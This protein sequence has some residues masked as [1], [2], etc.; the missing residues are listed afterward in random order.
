MLSKD[1]LFSN[2]LLTH[3]I[4]DN[5]L[6]E[7]WDGQLFFIS[8]YIYDKWAIS[9][10]RKLM[11][12]RNIIIMYIHFLPDKKKCVHFSIARVSEWCFFIGEIGLVNETSRRTSFSFFRFPLFWKYCASSEWRRQHNKIW[13]GYPPI[14]APRYF[15]GGDMKKKKAIT[16]SVFFLFFSRWFIEPLVDQASRNLKSE[17]M[18]KMKMWYMNKSNTARGLILGE[19]AYYKVLHATCE[20]PSRRK[21]T[22]IFF[23]L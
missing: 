16:A 1:S 20:K 8:C 4:L 6:Q 21:Y 2:F 9:L 11:Q 3:N 7:P 10:E 5:H 17:K 19:V 13:F 22:K 14:I 18:E 12:Y 23:S 15:S